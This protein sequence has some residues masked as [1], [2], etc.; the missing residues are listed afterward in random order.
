VDLSADRAGF[1]VAH[2]LEVACEM[3]K[4]SDEATAAVP[5]RDRIKELTLFAVSGKYF[6]LRKKLGITIDS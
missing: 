4:A 6:R 3:I 5:H 1:L 2:D